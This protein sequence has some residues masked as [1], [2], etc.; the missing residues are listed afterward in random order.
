MT[1]STRRLVFDAGTR[2]ER[3]IRCKLAQCSPWDDALSSVLSSSTIHVL[4]YWDSK[5]NG[6]RT[7]L[8][9]HIAA[10]GS[11]P[12]LR[13]LPVEDDERAREAFYAEHTM[14]LNSSKAIVIRV[15]DSKELLLT[16]LYSSHS[17]GMRTPVWWGYQLTPY[18]ATTVSTMIESGR[19][20]LVFD[21]DETLLVA[22]SCATLEKKMEDCRK[23][24]IEVAAR[25]ERLDRTSGA[26]GDEIRSRYKSADLCWQK[27]EELLQADNKLLKEFADNDFISVNGK[28]VRASYEAGLQ[29]DGSTVTRPVIRTMISGMQVILTR[30]DP[31]KKETSMILRPRPGWEDLRS[32]I[33]GENDMLGPGGKPKQ[34][35]EVYVCTAAERRYA[36]EVWRLL[37]TSGNLIPQE[38]RSRRI[39][40]VNIKAS[41]RKGVLETL[42]IVSSI[43]PSKGK[44]KKPVVEESDE[45]DD[46]M[47]TAPLGAMPLVVVVDDRID[48]WE[49]WSKANVLQVLPWHFYRDEA[50]RLAGLPSQLATLS[51]LELKRVRACATRLRSEAFQGINVGAR[52]RLDSFLEEG[53]PE[54]EQ[55]DPDLMATLL[56]PIVS[57]PMMLKDSKNAGLYEIP[58]LA[59]ASISASAVS[60]VLEPPAPSQPPLGAVTSESDGITAAEWMGLGVNSAPWPRSA[61][62][63][64]AEAPKGGASM[65]EGNKVSSLKPKDPRASR[66]G[67]V[68]TSPILGGG[69]LARAAPHAALMPLPSYPAELDPL[70]GQQAHEG[71]TTEV[72]SSVPPSMPQVSPA[73]DSQ[74][75]LDDPR[76]AAVTATTSTPASVSNNA[77]PP[78]SYRPEDPRKRRQ[79]LSA[80]ISSDAL[81]LTSPLDPTASINP[82]L[83]ETQAAPTGPSGS[84]IGSRI[85]QVSLR[86]ASL[87][88]LESLT[89]PDMAGVATINDSVAD[90]RGESQELRAD[91]TGIAPAAAPAEASLLQQQQQ[92]QENGDVN[93]AAELLPPHL[94]PGPG[95]KAPD[96]PPFTGDSSL[97]AQWLVVEPQP[98]PQPQVMFQ[99][100]SRPQPQPQQF[101]FMQTPLENI[102][103]LPQNLTSQNPAEI[104]MQPPPPQQPQQQQQLF[105][106][107]FQ[108][109]PPPPQHQQ[110]L[111]SVSIS[112]NVDASGEATPAQLTAFLALLAQPG[113]QEALLQAIQ[114]PVLPAHPV[115]LRQSSEGA[116]SST[117]A[118]PAPAPLQDMT[119]IMMPDPE[120]QEIHQMILNQPDLYALVVREI[121]SKQEE[122]GKNQQLAL[123]QGTASGVSKNQPSDPEAA[124]TSQSSLGTTQQQTIPRLHNRPHQSQPLAPPAAPPPPPPPRPPPG[125]PP[126]ASGPLGNTPQIQ[127]DPP[128]AQTFLPKPPPPP[129]PPQLS[130][131]STR[132]LG[133]TSGDASSSAPSLVPHPNQP[134]PPPPRGKKGQSEKIGAPNVSQQAAGKLKSPEKLKMQQGAVRKLTT[135]HHLRHKQATQPGVAG[136]GLGLT[137]TAGSAGRGH[138]RMLPLKAGGAPPPPQVLSQQQQQQIAQHQLQMQGHNSAGVGM[139]E[140]VD[141]V[142]RPGMMSQ[143][144]GGPPGIMTQM[145]LQQLPDSL[146][147][148]S[149]EWISLIRQQPWVQPQLPG[150]QDPQ[151]QKRP[152]P[153]ILAKQ[154]RQGGSSAKQQLSQPAVPGP[155]VSKRTL[156]PDVANEGLGFGPRPLG[157]QSKQPKLSAGSQASGRSNKVIV[158]PQPNSNTGP[159]GGLTPQPATSVGAASDPPSHPLLT[160]LQAYTSRNKLSDVIHNVERSNEANLWISTVCVGQM[161]WQSS[162]NKKKDSLTQALKEACQ[163]LGILLVE[164]A[165]SVVQGGVVGNIQATKVSLHPP[166]QSVIDSRGQ[167]ENTRSSP[168]TEEKMSMQPTEFAE[169]SSEEEEGELPSE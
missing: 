149:S 115:G 83:T 88:S 48:V 19:L 82:H 86:N 21:L 42:G 12:H 124:S 89:S 31:A 71:S 14:C 107:P 38:L 129:P 99:V 68:V 60:V 46:Y 152:A 96:G 13:L 55:Q 7:L 58:A 167:A 35:F 64:E 155:G 43:L 70:P 147:M 158:P 125:M 22:N 143:Q 4:A 148:T 102:T 157:D 67:G 11:L 133:T 66:R 139:M 166:L 110:L 160:K 69:G 18:L 51:E 116:P 53:A 113:A 41:K 77:A 59:T 106:V 15:S 2:T 93:G 47:T 37:D 49:K 81:A 163:A 162:S 8:A 159:A 156:E 78:T 44:R 20:G 30:I 25:M 111:P 56:P 28:I 108:A 85:P 45:E 54:Y 50:Q 17:D 146:S 87:W 24:R 27:E 16:A 142:I 34:R 126:S 135:S 121:Q 153:K 118:V 1:D 137:L 5:Q 39:V 90:D 52:L 136:R 120:V 97:Q 36:L 161:K 62:G 164:T 145:W 117:E 92:Q 91:A 9:A 112:S 65:E 72:A 132:A 32:F 75:R 151:T 100:Q 57:V 23:Q 169:E 150:G 74:L 141:G 98:Q 168:G 84:S 119:L 94:L 130:N 131:P 114:A 123:Q 29:E 154:K 26:E 140:G 80:S 101:A 105:H 61:G 73:T 127:P 138:K 3:E 6:K 10:S 103:G 122:L 95:L 144:L 165:G 33:A 76:L 79:Q 63:V 40:N 128:S 134:P 104:A 109:Q